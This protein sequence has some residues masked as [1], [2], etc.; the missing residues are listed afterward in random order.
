MLLDENHQPIQI[1]QTRSVHAFVRSRLLESKPVADQSPRADLRLITHHVWATT[2][3]C[4]L[5]S[6]WLTLSLCRQLLPQTA[7]QIVS[8]WQPWCLSIEPESPAPVW[9]PVRLD[10][11]LSRGAVIKGLARDRQSAT[12]ACDQL[13]DLFELCREPA[14]LAKAP[15]GCACAYKDMGRCPAACD[16]SESMTAYRKRMDQSIEFASGMT[17]PCQSQLEHSMHTSAKAELFEQAQACKLKLKLVAALETSKSLKLT[18]LSALSYLV[19]GQ[20]QRPGWQEVYFASPLGVEPLV[21]MQC[22]S[23]DQ[24]CSEIVNRVRQ[25]QES[26]TSCIKSLN[27][28]QLSVLFDSLCVLARHALGPGR[29]TQVLIAL[30]CAD[31]K[32]IRKLHQAQHELSKPTTPLPARSSTA[33]SKPADQKESP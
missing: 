14:E 30:D 13:V 7:D 21:F 31:E 24:V 28:A 4:P 20:S 9:R 26:A 10:Q 25:L 3:S 5:A 33:S 29:K 2:L 27:T 32:R 18:P 19:I 16:G 1:A 15:S 12:Q 23:R 11:A 6:D 17:E 22:P 8:K